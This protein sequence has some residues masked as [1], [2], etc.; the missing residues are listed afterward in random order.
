MISLEQVRLL[1]TK[2]SKA[3]EYVQRV[4]AENAALVSE[5]AGLQA[6][7]EANKKRIDELEVLVMRFKEDQGR[8]EDGI[9]AA[10]DRLSQFEEAFENS[11]KENIT[12]KK[13][14]AKPREKSSQPESSNP[15]VFFEIPKKET[16]AVP[17]TQDD[18]DDET[19]P[20]GELD[21]F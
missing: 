11:L 1:E 7:L 6:K 21:I 13:S 16:G 5:R 18:K 10:L 9:I 8:I 19:T 17:E 2:V 15:E 4:N 14:A 12:A 20:A 3:I